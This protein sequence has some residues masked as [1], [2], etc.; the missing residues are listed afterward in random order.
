MIWSFIQVAIGGA[1]GASMRY[2]SILGVT[3]LFGA[4]FPIGTLFVN[5]LGS[6]LLGFLVVLIDQR[7]WVSLTPFI[8]VGILGGFTT[9]S[10]FSLDAYNLFERGDF[11]A[12]VAYIFFSV[13]LSIL[14]LVVGIIIGRYIIL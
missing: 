12:C 10:A 13:S 1:L 2:A 3:R 5:I 6:I 9:F 4:G 8:I 14:A 11:L 7:N